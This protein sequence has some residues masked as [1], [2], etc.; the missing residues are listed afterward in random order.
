MPEKQKHKL[1]TS[2]PDCAEYTA[3]FHAIW[4]AY[5][6]LDDEETAKYPN[7]N[8]LDHPANV[9]LCPAYRECC[10]ATKKLQQEYS[11]LFI[12]ENQC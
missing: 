9:I 2:H 8:G 12:E 5:F 3:R 10:K 7:W 6:A 1:D 11:Y 4:D